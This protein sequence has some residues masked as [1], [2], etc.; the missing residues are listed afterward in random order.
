MNLERVDDDH[1]TD[2][3]E[4]DNHGRDD[5][6]PGDARLSRLQARVRELEDANRRLR[7][8]ERFVTNLLDGLAVQIAVL[9]SAGVILAANKAWCTGGNPSGLTG[10]CEGANYL[11]FCEQ[12]EESVMRQLGVAIRAVLAGERAV[13]ELQY[14][15]RTGDGQ[16]WFITLVTRFPDD[17]KGRVIVTH[18]DITQ[19]VHSGQALRESD[20]ALQRSQAIAHAG[21]WDWATRTSSVT[22]VDEASQ[23]IAARKHAEVELAA[24]LQRLA[25]STRAAHLGIWESDLES[26]AEEWDDTMYE[27][28]GCSRLTFTPTQAAWLACVHPDDR[29]R[30]VGVE[31]ALRTTG[32]RLH[33][34]YRIVRPDG[35]V[36]WIDSYAEILL[37]AAGKVQRLVGVNQD[38]TAAI[39]KEQQLRLHSAAL[40][41]AANGIVITD[42]NGVIEWV[43][44]AFCSLTGY[45]RTEAIGKNPRE[46]VRSG[47]QPESFYQRLWHTILAGKV[48]RGELIN[49]RKDGSLY[50]EEQTITPVRNEDGVITH[51]IGIKQDISER[52]QEARERN[53]LQAQLQAQADQLAQIIHSVP[54]GV[55]LL[56]AT[57]CV[58]QANPQAEALLRKLT[59][60]FAACSIT[61]LGDRPLE[62]LL[63]PPPPGGWH[64]VRTRDEEFEVAAQPVAAGPIAAGWVLVLR[65]VTEQRALHQQLQRQERL[66]AVGQ[67]AAGIA[68]DF[69]NIMSV[70]VAYA[71]LLGESPGLTERARSQLN[72]IQ[73]QAL[74]A[75]QMIRQI[76]DFSRRSVMDRHT[77][78]LLPLLKE[79]YKF[80][81]QTLPENIEIQ[82]QY[83]QAAHII[84]ADPTRLQQLLVNLAIN[85]RDA[86]PNGGLLRVELHRVHFDAADVPLPA[87][88]PG[89]WLQLRVSDTG[90]GMTPEVMAH[91]FEPFFTTKP[92]GVGTGL[93]L[94]QVHGIVAQHEGHIAVESAPGAGATF[95]LY[96][97]AVAVLTGDR[98]EN[99]PATL[100]KT[101]QGHGELVLVVEDEDEVRR[102]VVELLGLLH[103]RTCEASNGEEALQLLAERANDIDLVLSDVVMPK[104]GGLGLFHEMRRRNCFI[105][106][107]LLTG[108][109]LGVEPHEL[110]SQGI[111]G[112]LSKPPPIKELAEAIAQALDSVRR[113][114]QATAL[115]AT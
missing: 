98:D 114:G 107:L 103:Y 41:A 56:D 20:D 68:H 86:M 96:F 54:D 64:L 2:N 80:L 37:D 92:S 44:S 15:Y 115:R 82:L 95:T 46:L 57:H 109:P 60:T 42:R 73:Q 100:V 102:A 7:E 61:H 3:L 85:A 104:L 35:A 8:R 36:R 31:Q 79:Q 45:L 65:N 11:A 23:A 81:K 87:M 67:L 70:I 49:R 78:D 97:P 77:F 26:G 34:R 105:P 18:E 4:T 14:P 63:A 62:E 38:I 43:N 66:A 83:D 16:R 76:L 52:V 69:N 108:H 48:W 58:V 106:L 50:Y 71:Q 12:A 74:R 24:S 53:Q 22:W 5:R 28:Y 33:N 10:V 9:D 30:L 113:A 99:T 1:E 40:E 21:R 84:R 47:M 27:I 51:F 19:R 93:G 111:S 101:P 32:T 39:E 72:T 29:P 55:L 110:M 75:T 6:S 90:V 17:E 88:S 89:A 91:I 25:I 59:P 112:W 94:A 13:S